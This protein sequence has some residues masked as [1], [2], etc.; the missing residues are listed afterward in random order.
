MCTIN[1]AKIGFPFRSDTKMDVV[2]IINDLEVD[3]ESRTPF[4]E[5]RYPF[6]DGERHK[7]LLA[8]RI[9]W[10]MSKLG[11]DK[12]KATEWAE[13]EFTAMY[14]THEDLLNPED[15]Y[16]TIRKLSQL[17]LYANVKNDIINDTK[18]FFT[19]AQ[20]ALFMMTPMKT[21]PKTRYHFGT[22]VKV[23][24]GKDW[25]EPVSYWT[26]N[27]MNLT[28]ILTQCNLTGHYTLEEENRITRTEQTYLKVADEFGRFAADARTEHINGFSDFL[29]SRL[30]NFEGQTRPE[31]AKQTRTRPVRK[32]VYR[33]MPSTS[34]DASESPVPSEP[35]SISTNNETIIGS[36]YNK[37]RLSLDPKDALPPPS[38]SSLIC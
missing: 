23:L 37:P 29:Q 4:L 25:P 31:N 3:D 33:G 32:T 6:E 34:S 13:Q 9:C 16:D 15:P 1:Q 14:S 10:L 24:R 27:S 21:Y 20:D 5:M 22:D 2:R 17:A 26:A 8:Q 28:N 7:K 36:E 38:V 35:E 11:F 12:P 19:M 30:E 18:K